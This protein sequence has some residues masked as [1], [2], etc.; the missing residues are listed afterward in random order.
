MTECFDA[1]KQPI[2]CVVR[3]PEPAAWE[4]VLAVLCL[5]AMYGWVWCGRRKR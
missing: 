5:V 3:V 4:L 2:P 1:L